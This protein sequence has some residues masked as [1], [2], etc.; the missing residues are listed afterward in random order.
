M[1]TTYTTLPEDIQSSPRSLSRNPTLILSAIGCVVLFGVSAL[2]HYQFRSGWDLSIF[3]QG[4]YLISQGKTPDSSLL[5]IHM[6]ADHASFLLYPIALIYRVFTTPYTLFFLQ[7]LALAI[8][9]FPLRSLAQIAGLDRS[10]TLALLVSYLLYPTTLF[11]NMFDFHPEVL[12]VPVFFWAILAV[13][14]KQLGWFALCLAVILSSRDALALNVMFMGLWLLWFERERWAGTIAIAVGL[15]WFLIA[16]KVIGP[17][18]AG[19]NHML[20]SM[21]QMNY[22]YLGQSLP[23]VLKN[24]VLH[25]HLVLDKVIS[26]ETF[27]YL[28][29]LYIPVFWGLRLSYMAPLIAALPTL[30]MN[31]LSDFSHQ[32]AGIYQYDVPIL[33]FVFLAIIAAMGAQKTW[34]KQG[35]QIL[36]WCCLLIMLGAALRSIKP[37][38]VAQPYGWAEIQADY[39]ALAYVRPDSKVLSTGTF[40]PH[41]S[42]RPIIGIFPRHEGYGGIGLDHDNPDKYDQIILSMYRRTEEEN[43]MIQKLINRLNQDRNFKLIY[44]DKGTY[45]FDHQTSRG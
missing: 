14:R 13:R 6:L 35:R 4:I 9:L 17:A 23:E 12:V 8:A 42:H 38:M 5:G 21:I 25:P 37:H 27:K 31:I 26:Y 2:R 3:I 28:L 15:A 11:A 34:F 24:L 22:G 36:I 39:R 45:L 10:K 20:E 29:L 30:G 7:A 33:P 1:S 19:E 32:T 43:Q 44:Q 16:T 18:F 40:Q 41:L